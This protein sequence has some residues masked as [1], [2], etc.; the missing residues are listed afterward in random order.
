VSAST[1]ASKVVKARPDEVYDAFMN[2]A[3]LIEW[4]PPGEMTGKIHQFDARVGGGYRISLFYPPTEHA[5][6]GKT[7]ER[8]DMVS[9][10]FVELVPARRIVQAVTFHTTDPSLMGA[11]TLVATFEEVPDGTDVTIACTDLP[12]GLRPEDN[13]AGSRESLEKLAKRFG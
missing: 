4:L 1:S 12:P 11:M 6:R 2:P 10:R 7:A 8:E 5:Y 3:I 13:E 9:V